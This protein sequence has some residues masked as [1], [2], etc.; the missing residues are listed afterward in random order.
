MGEV[1]YMPPPKELTPEQREHWER[2]LENSERAV[3]LAKRMLGL[4]PI[5]VGVPYGAQ[6]T[7]EDNPVA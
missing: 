1:I 5:E 2:H 6:A 4:I 7:D 3:A